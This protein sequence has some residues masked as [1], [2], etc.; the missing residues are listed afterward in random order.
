MAVPGL[1]GLEGLEEGLA[2]ARGQRGG[3][4]RLRRRDTAG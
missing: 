2:A 1:E 3:G 4:A